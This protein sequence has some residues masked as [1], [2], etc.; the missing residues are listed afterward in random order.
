[1]AHYAFDD[2]LEAERMRV[3]RL[4]TVLG[5]GTCQSFEAPGV[6]RGWRCLEVGGGA[7]SIAAW[8]CE[9]VGSDGYVLATDLETTLLETLR[10]PNLEVR[11]HD[12]VVDPLPTGQFD[13]IHTRWVLAW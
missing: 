7:G 3:A 6:G 1:M 13:L 4:H 9:R 10:Y 8:L 5:A 2:T 11:R 12:I